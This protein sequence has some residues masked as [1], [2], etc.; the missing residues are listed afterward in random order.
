MPTIQMPR[1]QTPDEH[2]NIYM[3][4]TKLTDQPIVIAVKGE[5]YDGFIGALLDIEG[6]AIVQVMAYQVA[7]TKGAMFQWR[8]IEPSLLRLLVSFN[9]RPSDMEM[10]EVEQM[11]QEIRSGQRDSQ[12]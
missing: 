11:F 3:S 2:T 8:E 5:P 12:R 9:Y 6:V 10:F 1:A 7:V 4:R